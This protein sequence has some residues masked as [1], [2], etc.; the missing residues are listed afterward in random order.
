MILQIRLEA[1]WKSD[2]IPGHG[3]FIQLPGV[4]GCLVTRISASVNESDRIQEYG[5]RH[6]TSRTNG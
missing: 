4:A 2:T 5:K 3:E 6:E 1:A